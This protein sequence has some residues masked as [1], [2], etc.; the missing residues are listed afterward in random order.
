METFSYCC[1]LSDLSLLVFC[2]HTV[3]RKD[4]QEVNIGTLSKPE[5][6]NRKGTRPKISCDPSL[7]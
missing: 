1:A 4:V 2:S 3:A 6:S 5:G 7:T